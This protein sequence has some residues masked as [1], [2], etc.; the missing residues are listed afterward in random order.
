MQKA[1]SIIKGHKKFQ[2][3][4]ARLKT[5]DQMVLKINIKIT[6]L[7]VKKS[8]DLHLLLNSH[9]IFKILN[10]EGTF[11]TKKIRLMTIP[12]KKIKFKKSKLFETQN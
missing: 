11:E 5:K 8:K 1:I 6:K 10:R 12:L 3:S 4:K 7:S 2:K 9:K